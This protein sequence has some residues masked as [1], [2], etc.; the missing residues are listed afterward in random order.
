MRPLGPDSD[1]ALSPAEEKTMRRR[2]SVIC[3]LATVAVA[4]IGLICA[5]GAGASLQL[6]SAEVSLSTPGGGGFERQAG[7]HPD[8]ITRFSVASDPQSGLPGESARDVDVDL[9]PGLVGNAAAITTCPQADLQNHNLG[10]A[11]CPIGAQIGVATVVSPLTGETLGLF[12]LAHGP[13]VP[14]LFGFNYQ[15][16]T[17]V[18]SAGVRPGDYRITSGGLGISQTIPIKSVEVKLW[19]VPADPAHD[20]L[21]ESPNSGGGFGVSSPA[22]PVPFLTNPTSCTEAPSP[23]TV[24]GDSWENPGI[25]DTRLVPADPAGVP[26]VFEGCEKLSFDPGLTAQPTTR[27][28]GA[29]T[30]LAVDFKVA[31]NEAPD[32]LASSQVRKA[33]VTFPAGMAVSASSAAGLGA[34]GLA[35]M[36]LDSNRAPSCPDSSKIGTVKVDSP[37]LEEQLQGDVILAKQKDNPFGSL[38]AMYLSIKGPG[39]Y[40]KLPGLVEADPSTGQLTASFTDTPQL[41]FERLQLELKSGPRAPLTT[42]AACGRYAIGTEI[43]PWSG[44]AP[45]RGESSFTIDRDCAGGGFAPALL[46]GTSDPVAGGPSPFNLQVT[47]ADGEQNIS[48]IDATLPEGLLAK[49]AGVPLCGDAQAAGGDCPASSQVGTTTVGAGV[50][51]EPLYV[52]QPGKARP[53]STSPALIRGPR[54][55]SWSRSRPRPDPSTSAPWRS[56]P[57]STST[58]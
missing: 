39:F 46:A 33:V 27:S 7:A 44:A 58:R 55:R 49:L 28:A 17:A 38:L 11:S 35:E 25:F 52:P 45:V 20:S 42:P 53:R 54:I 13:E 31:Q 1:P 30:G 2:S 26:F 6:E 51:S 29:P 41:P 18:I 36:G 43:T 10:Y 56:A 9:P 32:G 47:R 57:A 37:L 40:L 16:V 4:A 12:N 21:R 50:G 23:F 24:R 15:G 3:T 5:P 19:G 8:L 48:R 34:C 14:A 22:L